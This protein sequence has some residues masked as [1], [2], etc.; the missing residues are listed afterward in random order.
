MGSFF[1]R[2]IL[3]GCRHALQSRPITLQGETYTVCLQ[4]TKQLPYSSD[5]MTPLTWREQRQMRRTKEYKAKTKLHG[6]E[7]RG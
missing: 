1:L 3:H 7:K 2:L 5:R 4:C 6:T